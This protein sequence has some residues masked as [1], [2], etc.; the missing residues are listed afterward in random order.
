M[1]KMD[2]IK[3]L[4][5]LIKK[6]HP[7][8]CEDE[9]LENIYNEITIKLNNILDSI[10]NKN[11][12][13]ENIGIKNNSNNKLIVNNNDYEYYKLGIKY[14]KNIHPNQ[15][16]KNNSD[17]TFEPKTYDEQLNILNKIFIS[18]KSA[19]YYFSKVL[20]EYPNSEWAND[21]KEKINLLKKLYK[22]YENINIYENNQIIN[23]NKFVEEMGLK[24]M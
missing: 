13:N 5:I 23:S 24:I 6:Y 17:R 16:Y 10:K 7:D 3:Q 14:Y 8:L 20:A 2:Y 15:F 22:S 11:K 12:I 21:S 9:Y 18:F 1:E 19:E 4:K